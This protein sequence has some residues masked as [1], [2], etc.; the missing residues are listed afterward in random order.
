[1]LLRFLFRATNEDQLAGLENLKVVSWMPQNDLLAHPRVVAFISH[2]GMNSLQEALY[3]GV[4][5]I[6]TPR[7]GDQFENAGVAVR[8]GTG[9]AFSLLTVTADELVSGVHAFL[10]DLPRYAANGARVSRVLQNENGARK[11]VTI[12]EELAATGATHLILEHERSSLNEQYCIDAVATIAVVAALLL[13][14][15]WKCVLVCFVRRCCTFR[16]K[17]KEN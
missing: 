4:P 8:L 3:H 7:F 6:A 10:A 2:C 5:I 15:L 11:A 16:N 1:M 13:F 9:V 17:V 12:V 14:A